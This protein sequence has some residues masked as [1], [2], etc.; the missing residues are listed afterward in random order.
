MM[1]EG[2]NRP[3]GILLCAQKDHALVLDKEPYRYQR[4]LSDLSEAD[5][6]SHSNEPGKLVRVIRNWFIENGNLTVIPSATEI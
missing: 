2:G 3:I 1:R 5:I 4:A 6:S